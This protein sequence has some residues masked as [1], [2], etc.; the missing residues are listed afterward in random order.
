M[1]IEGSIST[2]CKRVLAFTKS[3]NASRP[4]NIVMIHISIECEKLLGEAKPEEE[5]WASRTVRIV[6]GANESLTPRHT[7]IG[8]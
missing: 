5:L 4:F 8:I 2:V 1:E 3:W 7:V 6:S